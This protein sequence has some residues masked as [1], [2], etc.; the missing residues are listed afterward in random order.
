MPVIERWESLS[1]QT[2]QIAP[3]AGPIF[4]MRKCLCAPHALLFGAL[5]TN[6]I[7]GDFA[8]SFLFR[9]RK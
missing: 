6:G 4:L 1:P 2:R 8:G 5:I 7:P 9:V 3:D